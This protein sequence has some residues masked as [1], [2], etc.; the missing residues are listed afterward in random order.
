MKTF[1][2][3]LVAL[4]LLAAD[5]NAACRGRLFQRRPVRNLL[6]RV[7]HPVRGNCI[8][9]GVTQPQQPASPCPGGRCR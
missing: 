1:M 8:G 5:A 2:F 9:G 6:H 3:S 4:A 7:F